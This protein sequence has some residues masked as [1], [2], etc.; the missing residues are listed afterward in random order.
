VREAT[1][2]MMDR[3]VLLL[4]EDEPLLLVDLADVLEQAG[5]DVV[6]C[7]TGRKAFTALEGI[8]RFQGIVTDIRLGSPPDGWEVAKHARELVPDMPIVYMSADSAS[9]WSSKGVPNSIM[10]QKPFAGAQI[11]TAIAQLINAVPPAAPEN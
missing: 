2:A 8:G 11:T 4:V 5:F 9:E 1:G 10:I 3:A 6:Q 7:G